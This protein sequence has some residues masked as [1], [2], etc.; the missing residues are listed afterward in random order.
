MGQQMF[1]SVSKDH[2]KDDSK[3]C[4]EIDRQIVKNK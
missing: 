4:N 1:V 2:C 3:V